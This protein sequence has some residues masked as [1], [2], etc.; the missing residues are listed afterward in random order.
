MI[1]CFTVSREV[2]NDIQAA[3]SMEDFRA[4]GGDERMAIVISAIVKEFRTHEG[5]QLLEMET[6]LFETPNSTCLN[7]KR[8]ESFDALH[9]TGSAF[10]SFIEGCNSSSISLIMGLLIRE[11]DADGWTHNRLCHLMLNTVAHRLPA[12]YLCVF[13]SEV[14]RKLESS[15]GI[16]TAILADSIGELLKSNRSPL[17]YT[18]LEFTGNL[19][20]LLRKQKSNLL[21][22]PNDTRASF[23]AYKIPPPRTVFSICN[24]FVSL[25]RNANFALQKY[26]II[27][28]LLSK[29]FFP[30]IPSDSVE[31]H[32]SLQLPTDLDR[33]SLG[34]VTLESNEENHF[35]SIVWGIL[36]AL[37]EEGTLPSVLRFAFVDI[38]VKLFELLFKMISS[39]TDEHFSLNTIVFWR[40]LISNGLSIIPNRPRQEVL[41]GNCPPASGTVLGKISTYILAKTRV[42]LASFFNL[43]ET[44]CNISILHVAAVMSLIKSI[45]SECDYSNLISFCS[46]TLWMR[47]VSLRLNMFSFEDRACITLFSNCVIQA[48][49]TRIVQQGKNGFLYQLATDHISRMSEYG[50]SMISMEDTYNMSI[51]GPIISSS[52]NCNDLIEMIPATKKIKKAILHDMRDSEVSSEAKTT[53]DIFEN[54]YLIDM[55]NAV[56]S[57]YGNNSSRSAGSSFLHHPFLSVQSGHD[58]MS[59]KKT[60]GTFSRLSQLGV[61][62]SVQSA[63]TAPAFYR[64][65]EGLNR[66][67]ARTLAASSTS[68]NDSDSHSL[69]TLVRNADVLDSQFDVLSSRARETSRKEK[70]KSAMLFSSAKAP[71]G[72]FEDK[73]N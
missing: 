65:S 31:K 52:N 35:K 11:F 32:K 61:D 59:G 69:A 70:T 34:T 67:A 54:E 5:T 55:D 40:E 33:H 27:E 43:Q 48:I 62:A 38:H 21:D 4:P 58:R 47:K 14:F 30:S 53:V 12:Q 7:L 20:K 23:I 60:V 71:S 64:A 37:A 19:L 8:P 73:T 45:L 44:S 3:I 22:A 15:D 9:V 18:A 2:A 29:S 36:F 42:A 46:F 49:G 1:V 13:L 17:G 50:M 16:A 72:N 68:L 10:L 63:I 66:T 57:A 25:L 26:E 28:Y 51:S 6:Y 39:D 56:V 24:A 41:A